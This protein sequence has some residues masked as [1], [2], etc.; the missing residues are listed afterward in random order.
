M[1]TS[2]VG[3]A[4]SPMTNESFREKLRKALKDDSECVESF[5]SICYYHC[6][7]YDST[8]DFAKLNETLNTLEMT[9][10]HL[11]TTD[12]TG[13]FACQKNR[14]FYFAIPPSVFCP[15]SKCIHGMNINSFL[16]IRYMYW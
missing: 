14:L 1:Y 6:G 16:M 10:C 3:Y 4:R 12:I 2:I 9:Q 5:L 11:F 15:V 7:Q 8:D 13:K